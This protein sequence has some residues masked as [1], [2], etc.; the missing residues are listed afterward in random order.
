MAALSDV[1]A[2]KRVGAEKEWL[3]WAFVLE[4]SPFPKAKG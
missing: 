4:S 3:R 1:V 2:V